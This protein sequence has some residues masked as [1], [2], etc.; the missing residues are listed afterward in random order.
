MTPN[1]GAAAPMR[2]VKRVVVG[3]TGFLWWGM[4]RVERNGSGAES[5]AAAVVIR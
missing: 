5:R 1:Q 2:L 3:P 4:G